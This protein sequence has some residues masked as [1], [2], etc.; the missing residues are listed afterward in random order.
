MWEHKVYICLFTCTVTSAVHLEVVTDL[1]VECF[2]QAFRHFSSRKSLPRLVLS[3][4]GSNFL[5]AA[6]ELKTLLSSPSLASAL[7][8]SGTEWRFNP[9]RAPWFGGFW[10]R[11]IG[12]TKLT[13]KNVLGRALTASKP[14]LLRLKPFSMIT[15]L[16]MSLQMR[17]TQTQS[18]QPICYMVGRWLVHLIT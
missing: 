2:L 9:K 10:E 13:L 14:S 4:N 8:K 15:P 6:D 3:D 12:L 16:L 11:L 1:M 5:S 7:S 18:P 17:M